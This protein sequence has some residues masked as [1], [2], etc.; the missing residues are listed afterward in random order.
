[1]TEG[2]DLMLF[3]TCRVLKSLISVTDRACD[4][5]EDMESPLYIAIYN[6]QSASVELL[7]KEGFSPDAQRLTDLE[8]NSPLAFALSECTNMRSLS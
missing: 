6:D 3:F 7:L 2:N 8:M 4:R 1:M 5:G